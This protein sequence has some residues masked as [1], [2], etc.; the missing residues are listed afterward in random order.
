MSDITDGYKEK[1]R[2][3]IDKWMTEDDYEIYRI[4]DT[5]GEPA[6]FTG[7]GGFVMYESNV[8]EIL[9]NYSDSYDIEIVEDY[10]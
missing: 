3:I 10:R 2:I 6:D 9:D 5:S 8:Q 7:S 1:V 4:T